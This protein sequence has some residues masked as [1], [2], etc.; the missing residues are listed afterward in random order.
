M[1]STILHPMFYYQS[2][3]YLTSWEHLNH[4]C[5]CLCIVLH[6]HNVSPSWNALDG[7]L[8]SGAPNS[9]VFLIPDHFLYLLWWIVFLLQHVNS[10]ML[11]EFIH[12]TL[13]LSILILWVMSSIFIGFKCDLYAVDFK[14]LNSDSTPLMNFRLI[15]AKV[16]MNK[17]LKTNS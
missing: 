15:Y 8:V 3:P 4:S 17:F 16:H 12:P 1:T 14:S 2:S 6:S 7:H 9:L 13:S 11:Q 5:E 10:G